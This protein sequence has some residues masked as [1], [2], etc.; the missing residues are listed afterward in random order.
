LALIKA[1]IR[2]L[3]DE[4]IDFMNALTISRSLSTCAK[5]CISRASHPKG[6]KFLPGRTHGDTVQ[7]VDYNVGASSTI[8]SIADAISE[9]L[10]LFTSDNRCWFNGSNGRLEAEGQSFEGGYRV[11]L[12]ARWPGNIPA[13]NMHAAVMN[14]DFSPPW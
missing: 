2:L 8:S 11:P 9:T 12:I 14:I 1:A 10:V 3:T 4:A 13:G 6:Q 5:G 7:E